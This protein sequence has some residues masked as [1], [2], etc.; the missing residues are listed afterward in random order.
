[1]IKGKTKSGFEFEV[2]EDVMDN[3]LM[4]DALSDTMDD[5]PLAFARVCSLLLGKAQK[6]ELY[7]HLE[8]DGKVKVEDVSNEIADIFNALGEQGKN[9]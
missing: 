2:E 1:M 9:S 8:K 3:M 7:K 5:N 6:K 4:V